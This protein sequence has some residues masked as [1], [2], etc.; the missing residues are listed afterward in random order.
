MAGTLE[1]LTPIL[2]V[3]VIPRL[4][5]GDIRSLEWVY[6]TAGQRFLE[7]AELLQIVQVSA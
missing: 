4:S 5:L 3:H 2:E 7:D 1:L 6:R